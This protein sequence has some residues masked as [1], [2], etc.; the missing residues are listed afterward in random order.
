MAKYNSKPE[1]PMDISPPIT[2]VP[3]Y[4]ASDEMDDVAF[5]IMKKEAKSKASD[6]FRE[7]EYNAFATDKDRVGYDEKAYNILKEMYD[8]DSAKNKF[9]HIDFD[10]YLELLKPSLFKER[11]LSREG[12]QKI[13]DFFQNI[14]EGDFDQFKASASKGG[15]W[16]RIQ[17]RQPW[18]DKDFKMGPGPEESPPLRG[19]MLDKAGLGRGEY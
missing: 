11:A 7:S 15:H 9:K 13:G 14:Y 4:R 12:D 2:G 1:I 3:S 5:D 19:S 6:L 8:A 16:S 18:R 10:R 17:K